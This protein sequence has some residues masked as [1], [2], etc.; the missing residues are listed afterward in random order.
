[1]KEWRG[2]GH[3]QASA[4]TEAEKAGTLYVLRGIITVQKQLIPSTESQSFLSCVP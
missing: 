3:K 4:I 2:V 1:M